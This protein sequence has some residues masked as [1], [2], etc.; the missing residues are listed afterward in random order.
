MLGFADPAITL[1]VCAQVG[2]EARI[3]NPSG[4]A[5]RNRT[6]DLFSTRD[7]RTPKALSWPASAASTKA[8]E[9]G[10]IDRIEVVYVQN[11][12]RPES[13]LVVS[14]GPI[15][16]GLHQAAPTDEHI[17]VERAIRSIRRA[18]CR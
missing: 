3:V 13:P 8:T 15:K 6:D 10:Q 2:K 14:T 5:Y 11:A 1:R 7:L 9:L 12:P 16:G 4:A 18:S 17:S